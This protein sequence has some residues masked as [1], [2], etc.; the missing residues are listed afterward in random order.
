MLLSST[1]AR[2]DQPTDRFGA[3]G[4]GVRLAIDPGG[5]RRIQFVGPADGPNRVAARSGAPARSFFSFG[6]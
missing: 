4:L 5:D 3:R 1:K 6:Y 2:F